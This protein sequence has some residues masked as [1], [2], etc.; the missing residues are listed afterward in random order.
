M[1][2]QLVI[3]AMLV[4]S[5][6]SWGQQASLEEQAAT[7][8]QLAQIAAELKKR[9]TAIGQRAEQLSLTERQLRQLEQ[10]IAGVAGDLNRTRQTLADIR[11]RMTELQTQIQSLTQQLQNQQQLLAQQIDLAYRMGQH[12][13]L[14]FV[15]QQQEPSQFER[16]LGYYGYFNRARLAVLADIRET[17]QQLASVEA[18]VATQ[19]AEFERQE[20]QQRQQ[21]G[22]LQAQQGEQQQLIK[23]LQQEQSVDQRRIQELQQNQEAL[24]QVLAAIQAALRAEPKLNGLA[25]LKGKLQWPA[26]GRVERLFGQRRSGGIDWKGV[27]IHAA[28]GE[29]V[30]AIADGRVLFAN[31]LRGYGLVIVLDHG[32]GYMSLYGHN[33]T[34]LPAE[35]EIVRANETIALVGQSGGR[36]A[37]A[38]Y[39]EIRM[40]GDAV[41]PTQWCR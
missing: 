11:A 28:A 8:A 7:E 6:L 4:L 9:Q 27:M 3:C 41:N 30:R 35:G 23:R 32:N 15:L 37:P 16:L 40:K 39:F 38:L 20:Q 36:E 22:V 34:L 31:W 29:P 18:E 17:Q 25:D 1:I 33:Q 19:Q 24:E 13:Y 10:Q 5:P 26:K 2:R 12:D 21:Q 14:K